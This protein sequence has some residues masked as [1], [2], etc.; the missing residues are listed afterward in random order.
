MEFGYGFKFVS[1]RSRYECIRIK[2][3]SNLN[4]CVELGSFMARLCYVF[5]VKENINT[6]QPSPAFFIVW[7]R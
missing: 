2:K 1:I 7:C 5:F 3:F 4:P 6:F